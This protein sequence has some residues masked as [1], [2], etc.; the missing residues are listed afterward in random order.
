MQTYTKTYIPVSLQWCTLTFWGFRW[1]FRYF[2]PVIS[3]SSTKQ[4][5]WGLHPITGLYNYTM[6]M[7][8]VWLWMLEI[9]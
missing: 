2:S 6:V 5:S 8:M 1:I 4:T 7:M 9:N 3:E